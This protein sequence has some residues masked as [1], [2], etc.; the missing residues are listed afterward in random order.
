[1]TDKPAALSF[2]ACE[3]KS[4]PHGVGLESP[5]RRHDRSHPEVIYF[6]QLIAENDKGLARCGGSLKADSVTLTLC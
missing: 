4:S 2:V 3:N 6:Y 5:R 1:M